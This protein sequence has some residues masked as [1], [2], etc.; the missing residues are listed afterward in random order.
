MQRLRHNLK[1][2]GPNP[3]PATILAERHIFK[4]HIEKGVRCETRPFYYNFFHTMKITKEQIIRK[5]KLFLLITYVFAAIG[6]SSVAIKSGIDYF[7]ICG[8]ANLIGNFYNMYTIG[9][10]LIYIRGVEK[11]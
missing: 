4:C 1:I 3:A 2:A 6:S 5:L 7:V 11:R 10:N 8:I 9:H